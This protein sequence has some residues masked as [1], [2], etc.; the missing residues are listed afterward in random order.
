M[1]LI[2]SLRCALQYSGWSQACCQCIVSHESGGNGNAV[3]QNSGGSLDVG[4][5]Q[6]NTQNWA[7]CSGGSP[8]VSQESVLSSLL[9]S[10]MVSI[11]ACAVHAACLTRGCA[12]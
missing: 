12:D 8:P 9:S 4:L 6:V 11:S 2:S 5:W 10:P 1:P 3:N 7:S